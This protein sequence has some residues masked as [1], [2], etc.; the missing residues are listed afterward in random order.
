MNKKVKSQPNQSVLDIVLSE[1]GTLEAGMQFALINDIPLST[2][3]ATGAEYSVPLLSVNYI[4]AATVDQLRKNNNRIGT[5]GVVPPL[6][7]V[8]TLKPVMEVIPNV[9][10]APHTIGYYSYDFKATGDFVN[11]FELLPA[12]PGDNIVKYLTEE[13][14]VFGYV[15]EASP[16]DAVTSMPVKSIP[17]VLAWT[18]GL[19]Y[20]MVWSD[21]AAPVKTVTF[22]DVM[23]NEAYVA[24]LIVLDNVSQ[25][26]IEYLAA[27]M[28]VETVSATSN[29]VTVRVVRSHT[30]IFIDDFEHYTMEW[31]DAAITGTPDPDDP[32][33]PDKVILTLPAGIYT[34]GVKTTYT[35]PGIA[36]YPPSAFTMVLEVA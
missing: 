9:A 5:K 24:P 34:L 27:N 2:L 17:Y 25:A 22:R 15:P 35:F 31:L 18:T 8:I 32:L 20:M 3:P 21:L 30:S 33:N 6:T 12:Y 4:D 29:V 14:Y 7:C 23:G 28:E 19:G 16:P 26:V 36:I 11:V 1:Y 10:G 13:L